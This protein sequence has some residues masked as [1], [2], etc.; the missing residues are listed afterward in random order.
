VNKKIVSAIVGSLL[1]LSACDM[2]GDKETSSRR[3]EE[4]ASGIALDQFLKAQ[5]IP[6]FNYSQ[7]R[8]NLIDIQTAQA[9]ATATTSFFFNSAVEDPI[10]TCPSIGFPLPGTFQLTNPQQ[11]VGSTNG[12]VGIPQL[13]ATG[14]YTG[15]TAATT[16]ICVDD[17]GRG[18]G[19]YWEGFVSTVVGP[20]EWNADTNTVVLVGAPTA[21]FSTG[22]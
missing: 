20:A 4:K 8:Q 9:N 6:Q 13:E 16:V 3:S 11:I 10:H 7:I 21:E 14:V 17:Q 12:N 15:D 19:F 2:G 5:P 22:D 18:Y 1:L